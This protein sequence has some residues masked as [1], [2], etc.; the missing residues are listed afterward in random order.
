MRSTDRKTTRKRLRFRGELTD[1]MNGIPG[2]PL[3]SPIVLEYIEQSEDEAPLMWDNLKIKSSQYFCCGGE[4]CLSIP[5]ILYSMFCLITFMYLKPPS[6]ESFQC[7]NFEVTETAEELKISVYHILAM[8]SSFIIPLLA[9]CSC[10]GF[11]WVITYFD[12]LQPG[13]C[14]PT[15]M[16][17]KQYRLESGHTFHINYMMA[18]ANGVAVFCLTMWYLP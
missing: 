13:Q 15:P 8:L 14:P 18:I 17:P 7:I 12:S 3:C 10:C 16:S 11:S 2:E 4:W 5:L 6:S 1:R 9:A